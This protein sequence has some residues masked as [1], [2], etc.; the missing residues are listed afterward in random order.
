MPTDP[1]VPTCANREPLKG[2]PNRQNGKSDVRKAS[3]LPKMSENV[4]PPYGEKDVIF[5]QTRE[6]ASPGMGNMPV[7]DRDRHAQ[8]RL[9]DAKS[10]VLPS[11]FILARNLSPFRP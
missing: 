5:R 10:L 8:I 6:G 4:G 2:F 1:Y 9:L 7:G 3:G 11:S